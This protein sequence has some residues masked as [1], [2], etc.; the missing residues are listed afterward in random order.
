MP[1]NH[2]AYMCVYFRLVCTHFNLLMATGSC[3]FFLK[4]KSAIAVHQLSSRP[5]GGY[6][7]CID[8]SCC[9]WMQIYRDDVDKVTLFFSAQ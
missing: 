3:A 1:L 7:P 8:R 4:K 5:Q 6:T 2:T 9:R